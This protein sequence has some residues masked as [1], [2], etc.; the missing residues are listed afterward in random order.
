M[1]ICAYKKWCIKQACPVV[2]CLAHERNQMKY[3]KARLLF[4]LNIY[5]TPSKKVNRYQKGQKKARTSNKGVVKQQWLIR[6][7]DYWIAAAAAG[8]TCC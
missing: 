7:K 1:T 5:C 3:I 6:C 4:H 2:I 8:A